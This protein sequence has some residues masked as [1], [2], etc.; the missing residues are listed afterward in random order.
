MPLCH[1]LEIFFQNVQNCKLDYE[2]KCRPHMTHS[3]GNTKNKLQN[4]TNLV[5]AINVLKFISDSGFLF[6]FVFSSLHLFEMP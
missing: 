3:N 4:P 1:D 6:I 5:F 2:C